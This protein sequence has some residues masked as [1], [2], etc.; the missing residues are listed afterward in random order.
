MS[1]HENLVQMLE[2]YGVAPDQIA[3]FDSEGRIIELDLSGLRISEL[4]DQLFTFSSLKKLDISHNYLK[5]LPNSFESLENLRVLIIHNNE[6]VDLPSSLYSL[7]LLEELDASQNF[8]TSLPEA[9]IGMGSLQVLRLAANRL[10]E[11]PFSLSGMSGIQILELQN[12]LLQTLPIKVESMMSLWY[13]NLGQNLYNKLTMVIEPGSNLR[14]LY[15]HGN[16]LTELNLVSSDYSQILL[17]RLGLWD[18]RLAFLPDG[19]DRMPHL[20]DVSFVGNSL[21]MSN[22]EIIDYLRRITQISRGYDMFFSFSSYFIEKE[23][24]QSIIDVW[25]M[26]DISSF[27]PEQ[28]AEVY[29]TVGYS[30]SELGQFNTAFD[31][32]SKGV[33]IYLKLT[34]GTEVTD[35]SMRD[36][37]LSMGRLYASIGNTYRK[38]RKFVEAIA[39]LDKAKG[40]FTEIDLKADSNP[41]DMAAIYYDLAKYH[42]DKKE[43]ELACEYLIKSAEIYPKTGYPMD[44]DKV[45]DK[46]FELDPEKAFRAAGLGPFNQYWLVR[47]VSEMAKNFQ[48]IPGRYWGVL[49]RSIADFWAEVREKIITREYKES[50][51]YKS[52]KLR[53]LTEKSIA[54]TTNFSL[55]NFIGGANNI[56]SDI[57][58]DYKH[59]RKEQHDVPP[60]WF[61]EFPVLLHHDERYLK[62]RV[63]NMVSSYDGANLNYMTFPVNKLTP[64]PPVKRIKIKIDMP[65]QQ[66]YEFDH[67]F[68]PNSEREYEATQKNPHSTWLTDVYSIDIGDHPQGED[69][70]T[71]NYIV[72]L[73]FED[74]RKEEADVVTTSKSHTLPVVRKNRFQVMQKYKNQHANALAVIL[75]VWSIL[76]TAIGYVGQATEFL[77]KNAGSFD[78]STLTYAF[79]GGLVTL[80]LLLTFFIFKRINKEVLE[81]RVYLIKEQL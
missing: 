20:R 70:I 59:L 29:N 71:V 75:V 73:Y 57:E 45:L 61:L 11:L 52:W 63:N 17:E 60:L 14:E 3:T 55:F 18:N 21:T 15:L 76:S 10:E 53:F 78:P 69:N 2:P 62:I 79:I 54:R 13:L 67:I 58:H 40:I 23:E 36:I 19:L 41:E 80:G 24:W 4:P 5:E 37:Y 38:T 43:K 35:P 12:N 28:Q 22:S 44:V 26:S 81:D 6:L 25:S 50:E 34:E 47:R 31:Q 39:A 42:F 27:T 64:N 46:L 68:E 66:S 7:P 8:I 1:D 77:Q 16:Q 65:W 51:Y 56:E 74:E 49:H 72:K 48:P 30:Y 32:Y 9:M 33:Q